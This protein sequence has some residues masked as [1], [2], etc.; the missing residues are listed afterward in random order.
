M[1]SLSEC[2]HI[3][4]YDHIFIITRG[5]L[6]TITLPMWSIYRNQ[7]LMAD[8]LKK[9]FRMFS[10]LFLQNVHYNLYE[11]QTQTLR[12]VNTW[13]WAGQ[14]STASGHHLTQYI[15][16]ASLLGW[17]TVQYTNVFQRQLSIALSSQ[18]SSWRCSIF[19]DDQ[20]L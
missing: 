16:D 1:I 20:I 12:L 15:T 13:Y 9:T 11:T 17:M 10:Y 2:D 3:Y 4:M 18:T 19:N 14:H 8:T 6:K 7:A 5:R